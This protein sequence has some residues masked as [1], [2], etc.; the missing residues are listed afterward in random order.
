MRLKCASWKTF[1]QRLAIDMWARILL[2]QVMKGEK[3]RYRVDQPI[4]DHLLMVEHL[5]IFSSYVLHSF[6]VT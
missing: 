1:T 5:F 2:K 3:Q 4:I 6:R